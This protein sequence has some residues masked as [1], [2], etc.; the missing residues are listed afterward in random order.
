MKIL[1]EGYRYRA[2]DV[3]AILK[4]LGYT[5]TDH[6]V[7]VRHVGYFFNKEIGDTVFFLPKV[8]VNENDEVLGRK[9]LR[10]EKILDLATTLGDNLLSRDDYSFIYKF[11]VWIYRTVKEYSRLHPGSD[12]IYTTSYS[13]IDKSQNNVDATWLDII[14]SLIK[15]NDQNRDFFMFVVKNIHSGYNK[16]NWPRTIAK[17]KAVISNKKP[18]YIDPVNKKKQI[19]FDEELLVI[20]FSCLSYIHSHYGFETTIN[21]NYDLV[22]G[23]RFEHY[24]NGFGRARLR[25]IKYKYFSDKA[26]ELWNLCY[27]FFESAEKIRSSQQG[28]DC[29]L[30][31]KFEIVFEAIIDE[32]IGDK[33]TKI[34]SEL[35]EQQDGKI[36]DHLF[37][38][39]SLVCDSDIYYIGDSKYYKIGSSPSGNPVYK[40][41]TYAKNVIQANIDRLFK[42]KEHIRYRDDITE[43]YDITPNFFISAEVRDSLTYSDTSLKLRDKDWKA[44]FHF[45]NRL[46]DRDTLWL[47]HYD[48]NFL[49]VIALYARADE[50]EKSTF[51]EQA[52]KQFRTHIIDL[53]NTRY[54]FCLLRPKSNYTLAEAVDANFRKLNGKIFSPDGHIVVLAAERGTAPALEAEIGRYFEIDKGYKLGDKLPDRA[55]ELGS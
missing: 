10:P 14:L 41:Y 40:Q 39:Q 26:I 15:F 2:N 7:T 38:G 19:N 50:Y 44:M 25:Q 6:Y 34:P 48:V 47:S 18:V 3:S 27:S 13:L 8:L 24:L 55:E 22:T 5:F 29:M 12:I 33:S 20:F 46:F 37:L 4:G 9:D 23:S 21:Y 53:L 36:V 43:G 11:S 42:G 30:A 28:G 52:H 35:I 16:I 49:S 45:P 17:S 51:R 31:R 32:L 54:D 1:I